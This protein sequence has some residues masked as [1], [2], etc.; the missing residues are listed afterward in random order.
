[1]KEHSSQGRGILAATLLALFAAINLGAADAKFI[2]A[3]KGQ[4]WMQT[5]SATA[6]L[7]PDTN[8]VFLVSVEASG[9][10]S[11]TNGFLVLPNSSVVTIEGDGDNHGELEEMFVSQST[12]DAAFPNGTYQ[13][14]IEGTNDGAVTNT[15][16]ITGDSY[17]ATPHFDS[18]AAAQA[19]DP[20]TDFNLTWEPISG[21]TENDYI[22]LELVDCQDEN[23]VS[24]P[25]PGEAG[26]LNG[27]STNYVIRARSLRPGMM[28]KVKMIVAH[29]TTFNTNSYPGAMV[30]GGYVKEV[31]LPIAT[32]GTPV[33]CPPGRLQMVFNF[34]QGGFDGTNGTV[35]L[36]QSLA[37]YVMQ[38]EVRG[39]I[40]P[41]A[42]VLF[43]GPEG[44]G[45][46][47]TTNA[48]AS[49]DDWGAWFVSP[50]IT[51]PPY[52]PAGVYVVQY[53]GNNFNYGLLD[54]NATGQQLLLIPTVV[55]NDL[56]EVTEVRWRYTDTNGVE[57]DAPEYV[58]EVSVSLDGMFGP[59]YQ[60]DW[61]GE[62]MERT[63]TAH[64][65]VSPVPWDGVYAVTMVYRDVARNSF[66]SVFVRNSVPP[67]MEI[68]TQELPSGVVGQTYGASLSVSGGQSPYSWSVSAGVL[69]DGLALSPDTGNIIGHP[70]TP[71]TSEF[72]IRVTDGTTAFTERSFFIQVAPDGGG[73]GET[74]G[75]D[76]SFYAVLKG[77]RWIQ[78]NAGPAV[79][80]G[81]SNY[82]FM[83]FVEG[84][85]T[86]RLLGASIVPPGASPVTLE[87]RDGDNV[88]VEEFFP[89]Q[90]ALDAAF[91]NGDY[92]IVTE[93]SLDGSRTNS[94]LVTGDAY[95]AAPQI[96]NFAEAQS[97]DPAADF[98]LNW[99]AIEG[100][101][102]GDYVGVEVLDCRG[103]YVISAGSPGDPESLN[104]ESTSF[105]I[106]ARTLRP[107]QEYLVKFFVGRFTTYTT[108]D[109]PGATGIGG[110]MSET[111]IPLVTTGT[112]VDCAEG[113]LSFA[114][115][116]PS[117]VLDGTNGVIDFPT[118]LAQYALVYEGSGDANP[119]ETVTFTGPEG[120]GLDHATNDVFNVVQSG[121]LYGSPLVTVPPFP[122]G[123]VYTV[124][125]SGNDRSFNLLDPEA[126]AQ[127]VLL[128]PTVIVND[129]GSVTEVRIRYAD[130]NGTTID[131]PEFVKTID[132]NLLGASS[133]LYQSGWGG[134]IPGGTTSHVL[135]YPVPWNQVSVI[136]LLFHDN[137]GNSFLSVWSQS[138]T[139]PPGLE[140]VTE[141]LPAGFVGTNY[142]AAVEV[143]GGESPYYWMVDGGELP[144][145]LSLN[146]ETG[147]ISGAPETNGVFIVSI[148]VL[149]AIEDE[150]Q[151][152]FVISVRSAGGET[153][154]GPEVSELVII[155]GQEFVQTGASTPVQS[156]EDPFRFE[157][158]VEGS[159][160][161]SITN[162]V[163]RSPKGTNYPLEIEEM[164]FEA[165]MASG[166]EGGME[167]FSQTFRVSG[168]FASKS[169]MDNVFGN[170]TYGFTIT[171]GSGSN[172]AVNLNIS[173]D[174]YPATPQ[175]ANWEET[176][177]IDAYADFTLTWNP[178]T[179]GKTND[180]VWVEIED[181]FGTIYESAGPDE[182]EALNGKSTS[183]VI[184]GGTLE[185][186]SEYK[187][188]LFI[189]KF[190]TVNTTALAGAKAMSAYVKAT[191]VI[192]STVTPPPVEG[193]FQ[194]SASSFTVSET[195]VTAEF[196]VTRTGGSEGAVSVDFS[197]AD[198][199]A[200]AEQDYVPTEGTL[201]FADGETSATFSFEVID[202]D[203]FETN[204]TVRLVL[205]NPVG[206][207]T[208]GS[209]S[210]AVMIITDN[211]TPGE[212]GLLQFSAA[213]YVVSESSATVTLTVTRTGGKSGEV[214]VDY[215]TVDGDALG[216][217]D[218]TPD[219]G[220]LT[221]P[222]GVTSQTIV[223]GLNNDD[224]DET[225]ETFEVMLEAPGGG[226][227]LGTRNVA[228]VVITDNDNGGEIK[229]S[230][231]SIK[232]DETA[233]EAIVTLTRSGGTAEGVTVDVTITGGTATSEE[234]YLLESE[235]VE[236]AAGESTTTFALLINDDS[237]SEGDETVLLQLSNPT[238]GASLGKGTNA[239]VLIIDDEVSFQLA[240]ES[241]TVSEKAATVVVT[242]IRSGPTTGTSTV[243]L[244]TVDGT[245]DGESDFAGTNVTVTFGPGATSKTVPIR[246]LRDDLVEG[247]ETF[248]VELGNPDGGQLGNLTEAIVTIEDDDE[249]GE[250]SFKVESFKA[251]ESASFAVVQVTRT[252][253][254][255]G[256]VMFD[257]TTEDE[258][259]ED[260]SDYTGVTETIEFGAGVKTLKIEIP[261]LGDALDEDDETVHLTIS[262]PS[263]GATL[264][265]LDSA[266]LTIVDDDTGGV[267]AFGATTYSISETGATANITLTR[268]GGKAEGVWVEVIN[269]GG[270]AT[271]DVDYTGFLTNTVFFGEGE[272]K[273]SFSI[274]ITDDSDSDGNETVLLELAN[275]GGGARLGSR[276]NA[277]LNILD[278][279]LSVQ[280]SVTATN[281]DEGGKKIVLTVLRSGP[282]GAFTVQYATS[283]GSATAGADY[284]AK[285]GTLSFSSSAKSK[286]IIIPIINDTEDEGDETFTVTLTNPST[287]VAI[288]ENSSVTVTIGDNDPA[289]RVSRASRR[290]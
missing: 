193:Q 140:I 86:E 152:T 85:G 54:P 42:E 286:T 45:L 228:S 191:Y 181:E 114:F 157:T 92:A 32:T 72:L 182:P 151:R 219:F 17:P 99:S 164:M 146:E 38:L 288:G 287:G 18:F 49:A 216:E 283:D 79:A 245:A 133:P 265:E 209:Q 183:L 188:T 210:N 101:T 247:D 94:L 103:E 167:D 206:G 199:S 16:V 28:Y 20:A 8:H 174:N 128:V 202:D 47:N 100:A 268:S 272:T 58:E 171:T 214:T 155:K 248:G 256:G 195:N 232:V 179:G 19:I 5:N 10:E 24:T 196:T 275:P 238:G 63:A 125:Y 84:N 89:S 51:L 149:D 154:S 234:D 223:I 242:V 205:S 262:N 105:L 3:A 284:T 217:A 74:N 121:P 1:M 96:S 23:V 59:A 77:Q 71:G 208:L 13:V 173:G 124:N 142:S 168:R 150:V 7:L 270:T 80:D 144:P 177:S 175:I 83:S 108:N 95:P 258:S 162:V 130:T 233:G 139:P 27:T 31:Y 225:N 143:A 166:G 148:R 220:T 122:T 132:L 117:G 215:F 159:Y 64:L 165:P 81:G 207:A 15:I 235:T 126:D 176:Q 98:T 276:T 241:Y 115:N 56:N 266:T 136:E 185:P 204:E 12:M 109:Y 221:F 250:I 255:A 271:P 158:F 30:V 116:F 277:V 52:P 21:A 257:F 224:I 190:S 236:F 113:R 244:S 102:S 112:P 104:G 264:G 68:L 243:D 14:V 279:E 34:P 197:T 90:T 163:L 67:G 156:P 227:S 129:A 229:F 138:I 39:E 4:R 141:S 263:G 40:N 29:F 267:I 61:F 254:V 251:K 87:D 25:A 50:S 218:Y 55:L 119:P 273:V 134:E 226:A 200:L 118:G 261:L 290:R 123:G 189:A 106:P 66:I 9:P 65:V 274:D 160:Y 11:I 135:D 282:K 222:D 73:G 231:A 249:G 62:P 169:A 57:V 187:C 172:K 147:E 285:T 33:D 37:N 237:D 107:G 153:G 120:S 110:Y 53:G 36:P 213:S 161:G 281:V 88:R 35:S 75:A 269:T 240:A 60:S 260:G 289:S 280:F 145:G 278:D 2:V 111:H 212:A 6:T 198:G 127:Q 78:T 194:F 97:I 46:S 186:G 201:D 48:F 44:S 184:P 82:V 230:A 239:T 70:T 91:A 178:L 180:Y 131:A 259:A 41:P 43:S 252:G 170:G 26:A 137:A 93:G 246:L 203:I 22:S 69:P 211:D 192:L 76:V 253:G